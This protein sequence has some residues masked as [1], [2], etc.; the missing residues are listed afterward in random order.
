V[1]RGGWPALPAHPG[2]GGQDLPL[3]LCCQS[4]G[5]DGQAHCQVS[6]FFPHSLA[7]GPS[8]QGCGVAQLGCGSAR[9][10]RSSVRVWRRSVRVRRSS[11]RILRSSVRVRRS[12][13]RVMRILGRVRR[14]SVGNASACCKAGPSSILGSALH[15]SSSLAER[16]SNEDTRI[17]ASANG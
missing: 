9:V 5:Q 12:S 16:R 2:A 10:R 6:P 3:H 14:S 13:V 7:D 11:A 4:G 1:E 15:G 17:Q 8:F